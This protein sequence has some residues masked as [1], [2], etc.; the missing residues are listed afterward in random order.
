M[1]NMVS[2]PEAEAESDVRFPVVLR[3]Y[4]RRQVDEYVRVAEKR[5]ERQEKARRLAERRLAKAQ[6]PAPRTPENDHAGGLGKRIEKILEVA[7]SEAEAIKEQA[8]EEGAKLLAAAEKTVADA[9]KARADTELAAQREARSIVS[10]AEQ[11]DATIR[12]GHQ[13]VLDQ[14]GRIADVVQELRARFGGEPA[15]ESQAEADAAPS[16]ADSAHAG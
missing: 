7:K 10:R 5:V 3:G 14:L 13:S 8:R 1:E 4:D 12:A 16:P 2:E 9:E 15:A 11:E 6:V